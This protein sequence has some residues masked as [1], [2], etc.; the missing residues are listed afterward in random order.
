[1]VLIV[2]TIQDHLNPILQHYLAFPRFNISFPFSYLDVYFFP[3]FSVILNEHAKH[4]SGKCQATVSAF[5]GAN[6][7]GYP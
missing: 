7:R 6:G 4:H 2:L 1:M 3:P 5:A